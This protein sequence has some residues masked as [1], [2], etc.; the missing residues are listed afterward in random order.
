MQLYPSQP[1]PTKL[2]RTDSKKAQSN[3]AASIDTK[4]IS[5]GTT[6][7]VLS[8]AASE[9]GTQFHLSLQVPS[10]TDIDLSLC[11]PTG[12][13]I[14]YKSARG[15]FLPHPC[16]KHNLWK[17]C[18]QFVCRQFRYLNFLRT[19]VQSRYSSN[20][21]PLTQRPTPSNSPVLRTRRIIILPV[22]M[23]GGKD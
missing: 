7:N 13:K 6:L 17:G 2:K 14:K 1:V 18:A 19:V 8:T 12:L 9:R 15:I 4:R 20:T 3:E 10:S 22:Y 5:R 23:G 16:Q 11:V 21:H